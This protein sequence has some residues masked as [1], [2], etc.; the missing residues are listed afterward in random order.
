MPRPPDIEQAN[1]LRGSR[2]RPGGLSSVAGGLASIER[3]L[4]AIPPASGAIVMGCGIVSTDLY[5]Y[6]QPVLSAILL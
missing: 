2:D 1:E 6:H 3:V 4:D 5:S